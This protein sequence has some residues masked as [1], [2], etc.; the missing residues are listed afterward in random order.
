[1]SDAT[2]KRCPSCE[3]TLRVADFAGRTNSAGQHRLASYC[4]ACQIAYN[5][6]WYITHRESENDKRNA[7]YR[8]DANFRETRRI[9]SARRYAADP[10]SNRNSCLMRQ[11]GITLVEYREMAALQNGLCAI[12]GKTCK[13]GRVLAVDHDHVT[14]VNR[15]LL[16]IRCNNG[17]GNFRDD[18]DLLTAALE[19]LT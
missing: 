3:K 1:M 12:C 19:Y 9:E 14:G 15:G 18:P 13:S 8:E 2:T 17:L 10:D 11:F 16:C 7:R 4:K 5:H 6:K